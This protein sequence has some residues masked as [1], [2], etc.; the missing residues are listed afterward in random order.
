MLS[1]HS[2]KCTHPSEQSLEIMHVPE[3]TACL[4]VTGSVPLRGVSVLL[5]AV[6]ADVRHQ[7][8]RKD[9]TPCSANQAPLLLL[10]H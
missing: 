9:S 5:Q 8:L 2:L 7:N 3:G 4:S 1:L 10:S 6:Y